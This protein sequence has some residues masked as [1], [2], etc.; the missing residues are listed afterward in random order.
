MSLFNSPWLLFKMVIEIAILAVVIYEILYYL[1]NTRG[2]LVLS[3][4]FILWMSLKL[5]T[6]YLDLQVISY[7]MMIFGNSLLLVLFIIFQP[8]IRRALAQVGSYFVKRGAMRQEVIDELVTASRNLS[9]RKY[10][11]LIVVERKMKLQN[12]IEDSVRLDIKVNALVLE[13]SF[14]S[15]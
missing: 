1:R 11:A 4:F 5:L 3:G 9:E 15:K 14:F 10:G 7:I 13:S 8:E 6:D 2:S 12:I